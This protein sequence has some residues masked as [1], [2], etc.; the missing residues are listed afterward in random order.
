MPGVDDLELLA[1]WRDG[2]NRAADELL[3]RHFA[4]VRA[5]FLQRVASEHEDLIQETFSRL[6]AAKDRLRADSSFKGYLFGIARNVFLTHITLRH[7]LEVDPL[8]HSIADITGRR[9]SSLLAEREEHR[10]L[11]DALRMLPLRYQ[12]LLELYYWQAMTAAQIGASFGIVESTVRS[13]LATAKNRL[14]LEYLALSGAPHECEITSDD[15]ERWLGELG[16]KL[17]ELGT[18]DHD[19]A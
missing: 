12:E 3:R 1:R 15:V 10:L 17:G 11:L 19:A 16:Q 18:R 14:R 8:D 7:R 2:D 4:G 6:V 13:R 9:H 5:Y